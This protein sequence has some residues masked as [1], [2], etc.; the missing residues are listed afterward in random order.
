MRRLARSC[1]VACSL[2]LCAGL[3][4][5]K[6]A[7]QVIDLDDEEEEEGG[8][9]G[10]EEVVDDAPV[11][12]GQMTED[13]AQAKRLFDAERW[14]E[15][16]LML[17][18]V[19]DGETGDD[20]GNK[21]IAQYHLAIGLYRLQ[22]YQASYDLF[23]KIASRP[24]HLKFKETLLWLAKLAT[25][26]PEPADI[27]KHVGRYSKDQVKR[28]DNPQQRQL[29]WQLN[30]MLGRHKY[31]M[32]EFEQAIELF[33]NVDRESPYFV[34][35]QFFMGISYVQLRKS[36]PA[37][38]AFQ[39]IVEAVDEGVEGVEDEA[40]MRDLA[41]LS[42]ARTFY[43]ASIRLDQNNAPTIDEKKLSA[44]VKYW[45]LVDVASEYWLDALFEQ[46]WAYFMAGD[47]PHSLG[48]I[49]TIKS[50]Y[51]PNAFYPEAD[52]VKAV[53]YFTT[54]QYDDATTI[55]A[56]FQ[57]KYEPVAKELETILARYKGE[58]ADEKFY[59]FLLQV[60]DG[61]AKMS[62][63]VTPIVENA[64]S[65]RQLLRNIEYVKVL[66]L[67]MK[68]FEKAPRSFQ[69]SP[70]GAD[71]IDNID[72]ARAIAVRQAG[73]LARLRYQRNI[74]ELKEHLRNGQKII[75][76]IT[77]AQRKKLDEEIVSGQFTKEEALEYGMVKPDEEHV[78]WPFDGEYWRD[79]LGFYRQV[80]HSKCGE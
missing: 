23:Q 34:K 40:R 44:A 13:A 65:D 70:V 2:L 48:N 31:R 19:V 47:Y 4:F 22:F 64:L 3:A 6:P 38:R 63:D 20:E 80:V 54:C 78:L 33:E 28:F 39:R 9:E 77:N 66:D 37:V 27:I 30:Y 58:G 26:L 76:D 75:V 55:V 57:K 25:Q 62:D 72:L 68:R 11:T 1:L 74:D 5:A 59:Q 79:E 56:R 10:K 51:F 53:I 73:N 7:K 16:A 15:A 35:A 24:N 12:A 52:I 71:V 60:R 14:S 46:S 43:S 50:P 49:H 69:D 18:R 21:Q 45:N 36:V 67:E 29:Y 17:K 8:K 32:R 42:M 41:N 61:T